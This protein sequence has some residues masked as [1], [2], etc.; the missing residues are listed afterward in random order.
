MA[1]PNF[2]AIRARMDLSIADWARALNVSEMTIK[3]W[4]KGTDPV[5]LHAEVLRG[6][7]M[8]LDEGADPDRTSKMLS[9]GVGALLYQGLLRRAGL[10]P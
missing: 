6:I 9:L 10:Q 1:Q 4:S 3:R 5:G 8:A 2:N 7:S